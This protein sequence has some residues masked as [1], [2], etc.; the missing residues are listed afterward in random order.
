MELT[1]RWKTRMGLVIVWGI[2]S[3]LTA[4]H[5]AHALEDTET[6]WTFLL[7]IAIPASLS[8]GLLVGGVWLWQ[9]DRSGAQLVRISLWCLAGGGVHA[10]G[11]ILLLL[12]QA[13]EGVTLSHPGFILANAVS[14][15]CVIGLVVGLYNVRH[16]VAKARAEDVSQRLTVVNRILRHDVRNRANVIHGRAEI[17]VPENGH[18]EHLEAIRRQAVDLVDLG[19][20]ARSIEKLLHE[21]DEREQL[22][23]GAVLKQQLDR[24]E[25]D[26][27]NVEVEASVPTNEYID[28]HPLIE[29]AIA[30]ILENAVEHNDKQPPRVIVDYDRDPDD[31]GSVC[32]QISDNGPGIPEEELSVLE[33]G[34]ETAL[35]HTTGLGLWLINWI[36]TASDGEVCFEENSPEG[37]VVHLRLQ[38]AHVET[39]RSKPLPT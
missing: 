16:W 31:T 3:G 13:A 14:A 35:D 28:A 10:A 33:R 15:G 32:V 8:L 4:V 21:A 27:P 26:Y 2:G 6:M 34:Y 22:D 5:V 1:E 12:Y 11:S 30:N 18:E 37:S 29:S 7:G 23:I 20:N 36:V 19:E 39:A 9:S 24:L 25:Y 17:V 38:A